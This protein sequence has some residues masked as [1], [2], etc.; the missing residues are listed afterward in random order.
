MKLKDVK[1]GQ[2]YY[3][4]GE[5]FFKINSQNSTN[6]SE[7]GLIPTLEDSILEVELI[8]CHL[9]VLKKGATKS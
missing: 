7:G 2:V 8:E 9:V 6:L 4:Y 1:P 3:A 5:Y